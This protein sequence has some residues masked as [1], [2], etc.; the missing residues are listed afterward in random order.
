[1]AEPKPIREP[2]AFILVGFRKE[3][4]LKHISYLQRLRLSH[5][6]KKANEQLNNINKI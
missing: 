3:R 5:Q 4:E 6:Q 1:M 2:I